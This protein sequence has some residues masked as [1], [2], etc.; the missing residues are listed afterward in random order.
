[1]AGAMLGEGVT[2]PLDPILGEPLGLTGAAICCN[3]VNAGQALRVVLKPGQS[4][5]NYTVYPMEV[6]YFIP[7]IPEQPCL[8][9]INAAEDLLDEK[10]SINTLC[11]VALADLPLASETVTNDFEMPDLWCDLETDLF[12][13]PMLEVCQYLN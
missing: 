6:I 10:P 11:N 9:E 3:P 2:T 1:M 13:T 4:M 7:D 8:Y 5:T 12:E